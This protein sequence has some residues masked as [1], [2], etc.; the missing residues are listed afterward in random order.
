VLNVAYDTSVLPSEEDLRADLREA[1][2]LYRKLVVSGGWEPDDQIAK[3][4]EDEA[5]IVKDLTQA[6][7]YKQHRAIERQGSHSKAVKKAQGYRC[8]GC[9]KQMDEVYGDIAAELI[10]A[11]H[12]T[13]LSSLT[14]GQAVTFDPETDF[15]V[16]CPNCHSVIHRMEDVSNIGALRASLNKD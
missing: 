1:V 7:R 4:A 16:L 12:L 10:E 5:G 13:P 14:E 6:K 15:A 11:H 9:L 8:K 3:D 2:E